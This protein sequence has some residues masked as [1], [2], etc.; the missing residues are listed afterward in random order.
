MAFHDRVTADVT[1]EETLSGRVG[2]V[3]ERQ[4]SHWLPVI[5]YR[6]TCGYGKTIFRKL[7][8]EAAAVFGKERILTIAQPMLESRPEEVWKAILQKLEYSR[9]QRHRG[10]KA[11]KAVR[12]N[13]QMLKGE[14]VSVKM[15][16]FTTG[17]YGISGNG[18]ILP[19]TRSFFN[20]CWLTDCLWASAVT[21]YSFPACNGQRG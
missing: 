9:F 19:E 18:E 1:W 15:A 7:W 14:D 16:S 8:T 5:K 10:I 17:T 6:N 11:F 21:G 13:T 4:K 20:T 3:S 12:F 2:I